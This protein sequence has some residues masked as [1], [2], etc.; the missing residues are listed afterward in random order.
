MLLYLSKLFL[1]FISFSFVGWCLEVLYGLFEVK[2]FVNRGFLIGPLCPIYGIGCLAIYLC[3]S[4]YRSD[5]IVVFVMAV[6][7][8]SILEYFA[9]YIL[10]KIFKTRWWDYSE[11]K[12]NING[13]ICLEM[14]IPLG[15]LGLALVYFVYPFVWNT[16]SLLPN[17]AIYIISMVLLILFVLDLA[18]SLGIV[19][20]FKN[21]AVKVAKDS[22]EEI[23]KFVREV[24][25]QQSV[26]TKRLVVSFPNFKL[27]IGKIKKKFKKNKEKSK[28]G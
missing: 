2:K 14:L 27:N 10:E 11:M 8:C 25:V 18:F 13:R 5:A 23:S 22:T 16:L 19:I 20:K 21:T 7:I 28:I 3:L 9:S 12:L 1:C 26:W 15:L 6:A 24:L 17:M 4:K